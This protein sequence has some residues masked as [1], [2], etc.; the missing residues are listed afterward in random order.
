MSL[1]P[2]WIEG[3][4]MPGSEAPLGSS[5]HLKSFEVSAI[6]NSAS[7]RAWSNSEHASQ[8]HRLVYR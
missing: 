8:L 1:R 2:L 4:E 3:I 6:G 5:D 7:W